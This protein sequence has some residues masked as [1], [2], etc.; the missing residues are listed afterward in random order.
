MWFLHDRTTC[1]L[2]VSAAAEEDKHT[3]NNRLQRIMHKIHT[4][5]EGL[6]QE[7]GTVGDCRIT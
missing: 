4:D 3:A 1:G 2:V 6:G 5:G 7:A